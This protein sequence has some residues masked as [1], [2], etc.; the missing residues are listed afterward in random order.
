MPR[1]N[2]FVAS[3]KLLEKKWQERTLK[4]HKQK[5]CRNQ[6][7]II[8]ILIIILLIIIIIIIPKFRNNN[9]PM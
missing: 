6:L 2:G 8:I 4:A 7:L 1:S 9:M 5:V 3:S